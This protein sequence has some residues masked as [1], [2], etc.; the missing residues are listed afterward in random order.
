[1]ES[2]RR[3]Q[4]PLP[5]VAATLQLAAPPELYRAAARW[6]RY[7][8]TS[9]GELQHLSA[10]PLFRQRGRA[11]YYYARSSSRFLAQPLEAS[12]EGLRGAG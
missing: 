2:N 9:W 8:D 10:Y 5:E 1:M 6:P 12:R 4:P 11:L 7:L 3:E